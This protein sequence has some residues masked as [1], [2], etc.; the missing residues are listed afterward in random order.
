MT[1][2]KKADQQASPKTTH[3]HHSNLADAL[4]NAPTKAAR[5]LAYMLMPGRSLNRFE[6]EKL[7][8]HC[9][10]STISAF[11]HG[12]GLQFTYTLEQVPTRW[13]KPCIVT[14]YRLLESQRGAALALLTHIIKQRKTPCSSP[15]T[16]AL[17]AQ[18]HC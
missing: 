7:G 12:N 10:P 4:S 14:R 18:P 8:D 17:P 9:L 16:T 6:A 11:K 1:N 3:S 13:G 2:K 15:P 5:I